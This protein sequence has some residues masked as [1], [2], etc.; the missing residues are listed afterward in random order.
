MSGHIPAPVIHKSVDKFVE[1]LDAL[2]SE[3]KNERAP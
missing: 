3:Q 2:S 1:N